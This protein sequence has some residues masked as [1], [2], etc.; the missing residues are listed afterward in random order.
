M[1]SQ[2][3]RAKTRSV[4]TIEPA[5]ITAVNTPLPAV[6]LKLYL[7]TGN[8]LSLGMLDYFYHKRLR[9][10]L[11]TWNAKGWVTTDGASRILAT[12]EEGDG[13]S[14]IPMVLGGIGVVCIALAI[15][16]FIAANWDGIPRVAKLIGIALCVG[17]A[18]MLAARAAS[19]GRRGIADLATAFATL[20]FV[21]GMALVGQIFHLP[22]DWSGGAFLVCLGALA[23]AWVAGSRASL[24]VAACAAIA[25]QTGRVEFGDAVA[26][27]SLIGAA[28]TAVILLHPVAYPHRLGRWAAIALLLV[29]YGRW[30][31][32]TTRTIDPAGD[33]SFAAVILGYGGLAACMVQVGQLCDLYVKWSSSYPQRSQGNWLMM[34]AAQ[35]AGFAIL[36]T[37]LTVQLVAGEEFTTSPLGA[38][39]LTPPVAIAFA[40]ALAMAATGLLLAFQTPKS[41]WL[42]IAVLVALGAIALSL[43]FKSILLTAVLSLAGLIA[44]SLLGTLYNVPLWTL[45]G[46]AGLT[47]TI[48]Y[49][50]DVTVGSLLGQSLF[51]LIAGLVLLALAWGVTRL[52]KRSRTLRAQAGGKT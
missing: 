27:E 13:R 51:F 11:E 33:I 49:L 50:L 23:S 34:S 25:W 9:Q 47:A 35:A 36:A 17:G 10:D 48:L 21:G 28:I 16:A 12:L 29:T 2:G 15:A 43:A 7:R 31:A 18:H 30:L 41:R 20:V 52:M 38:A 42:F 39:L 5:T 37:L 1:S 45:C 44:I 32:D 46:Y 14:R 24:M 26:A 4:A 3:T 8:G 40:L 22:S 19:T 6:C